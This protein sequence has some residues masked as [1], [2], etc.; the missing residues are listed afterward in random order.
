V[1][2]SLFLADEVH[3]LYG[4]NR[5]IQVVY[6]GWPAPTGLPR[7][8]RPP[9]TLAAGRVWDSGKN[10]ALVF[11]A[12]HG[13][14]PG[15]VYVAGDPRHPDGG[16]TEIPAPC[17]ALGL[18]PRHEMDGWLA[19]ASV[20]LSAARYDPFGL[21]PLQAALHGCGLLLSDI[22]S[23]RELWDGAATFF[24]SDDA[25][26]LRRQWRRA[27]NQPRPDSA[28]QRALERYTA[29]GMTDAYRDVYAAVTRPGVLA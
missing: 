7:A 13:W 11:E 5:A 14:D 22:P 6:N 4:T 10:L 21:L 3:A 9:I 17:R 12:A 19:R 23:Y 16:E 24:R 27:L 18:L 8:P 29:D 25:D 28:Y 1:A 20:Y 2:V 26:D 15:E